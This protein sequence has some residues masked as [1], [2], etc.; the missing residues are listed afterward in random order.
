MGSG[1]CWTGSTASASRTLRQNYDAASPLSG[2]LTACG[3][4][5]CQHGKRVSSSAGHAHSLAAPLSPGV[6]CSAAPP[7]RR[8]VSPAARNEESTTRNSVKTRGEWRSLFFTF[9][10]LSTK[11]QNLRTGKLQ[12]REIPTRERGYAKILVLCLHIQRK[13]QETQDRARQTET[14]HARQ[15][16]QPALPP[17]TPQPAP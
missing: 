4:P 17:V 2:V 14:Q 5:W 8:G 13:P 16:P 15:E 12:Q 3:S 10:V 1:S 7:T 6:W 11:K 9:T